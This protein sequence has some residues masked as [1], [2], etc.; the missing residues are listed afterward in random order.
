LRTYFDGINISW[1]SNYGFGA[2]KNI[3]RI[4]PIASDAVDGLIFTHLE[5]AAL[6]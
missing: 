5:E 3:L 1:D 6:A 4:P 2:E